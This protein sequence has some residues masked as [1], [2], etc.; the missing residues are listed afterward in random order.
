MFKRKT[1]GILAAALAVAAF[2]AAPFAHAGLG[3]PQKPAGA[4]V[5]PSTSIIAV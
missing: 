5:P 4:A 2:G 1:T 3:M